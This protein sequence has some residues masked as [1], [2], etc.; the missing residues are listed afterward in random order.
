MYHDY[1]GLNEQ[2]FS[3]AVNPRYLYMS[4]QHKEALAHLLYGVQGGG[5]VMLTGEVGTGK[6]TIVRS[7]LEQLPD[8]TEIAI[9]LNPM[10]DVEDL[11]QTICDELETQYFADDMGIKTLT[12]ALH[13][14]LLENH[15]NGKNTV[16]LIDE[17]QLLAPE[18]LEQ[19]R[20]LTNLETATE[21]LLQII[22]VGQPELNDIL[23]Q[24]HLR[25]LSQRIVARF[26]LKPLTL[27]ETQY[28]IEHRL[29]VAG[30]RK[31]RN[32]FT[33]EIIKR[34]HEFSEGIPRII[35]VICERTLIGAYGSNKPEID[36]QI[37][38]LAQKEVTGRGKKLNNQQTWVDSLKQNP[39]MLIL[40][41]GTAIT[42]CLIAIIILLFTQNTSEPVNSG[43]NQ[44]TIANPKI[45]PL[46]DSGAP[47]E[48]NDD[49]N[50]HSA[51]VLA[52]GKMKEALKAETIDNQASTVQGALTESY[53]L[54][55]KNES[56]S[57]FF[58]YLGFELSNRTPPCWQLSREGYECKVAKL[59]TWQEVLDFNRPM[60]LSVITEERFSSFVVLVGLNDDSALLVDSSGELVKLPLAQLGPMWKG[61]I[62]YIWKKPKGFEKAL[63]LGDSSK[64]VGEIAEMF[65]ALDN[66]NKPL[67]K[68][69][70][71]RELQRRVKIFQ[72]THN[73]EDDGILGQKTL[74]KLNEEIGDSFVLQQEF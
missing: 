68:F 35:N 54:A 53:L 10:S 48:I 60:V 8:N 32:P 14:K 38:A 59:N 67:T 66:Q 71:N 63:K 39:F 28:Y 23:A 4:Q 47:S 25:Q 22:L 46:P 52:T 74:M 26:H 70:F 45:Y 64:L 36:R 7:L 5:F 58:S 9:V 33:P 49:S 73:M 19:I 31:G 21:K 44:N 37:L 41:F 51:P 29:S 61:D 30:L 3:I 62:F 72:Q 18:V 43:N 20:L 56:E 50:S 55:D 34:I 15:K 2:A 13:E 11:L 57:V 40:G 65:A 42:L 69:N 24:P 17:A 6:T 12:D 16:L 27:E 1:F